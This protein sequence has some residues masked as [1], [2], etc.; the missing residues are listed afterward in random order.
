MVECPHNTRHAAHDVESPL[1]YSGRA[2]QVP[3]RAVRRTSY[4]TQ[5]LVVGRLVCV[6]PFAVRSG[7]IAVD[8]VSTSVVGAGTY[9]LTLDAQ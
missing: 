1:S 6:V 3:L 8:I 4:E 9:T 7:D 5:T 2:C